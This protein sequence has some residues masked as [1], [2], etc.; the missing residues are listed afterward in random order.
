MQILASG[1]Q[2]AAR[3]G[4][5]QPRRHQRASQTAGRGKPKGSPQH[6]APQADTP[7]TIC[8]TGVGTNQSDSRGSR[9]L[10]THSL[11]KSE[12]FKNK[13]LDYQRPNT[14]IALLW[15]TWR[16]TT[17]DPHRGH[18]QKTG[19]PPGTVPP[20]Q[21]GRTGSLVVKS[22]EYWSEEYTNTIHLGAEKC[23]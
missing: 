3:P 7:Q 17:L 12:T 11:H 20:V 1:A 22:S 2:A 5:G 8:R 18:S 6:T 15:K 21:N 19:V 23:T 10:A 13:P 9:P 4:G 14:I 16:F